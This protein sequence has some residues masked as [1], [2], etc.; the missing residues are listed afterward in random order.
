MVLSDGR[1]GAAVSCFRGALTTRPDLIGNTSTGE[2]GRLQM[3]TKAFG[4]MVIA[5]W[6]CVSPARAITFY[7]YNVEFTDFTLGTGEITGTIQ[8]NCDGCVLN[9]ANFVTSWSLKASDGSSVSSSESTAET[10]LCGGILQ[11]TATGIYSVTNP[12]PSGDFELCGD[13]TDC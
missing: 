4:L 9:S 12:T 2:V 7:D 3:K 1:R 5:A 8:A 11:A 13:T 6:L 10:I